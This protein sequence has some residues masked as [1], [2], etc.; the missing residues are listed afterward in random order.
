MHWTKE[1]DR[2]VEEKYYEIPV[3]ELMELLP[4][5]TQ[6][7]IELRAKRKLGLTKDKRTQRKY[8][9]NMNFFDEPNV[10]NSYW[11]GFIAADGCLT[12]KKHLVSFGIHWDDGY[13]LEQFIK[14]CEFEGKVVYTTTT[15]GWRKATLY[16]WGVAPW[17]E[18]LKKNYE[19]TPQKSLTLGPPNLVEE[20]HIKAYIRGYL[21]GDGHINDARVG[22]VG[23]EGTM[24][25]IKKQ[26]DILVPWHG[27]RGRSN[28]Y[29]GTGEKVYRYAV[30]GKRSRMLIKELL[31]V[32]TPYLERK[33]GKFIN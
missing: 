15:E 30:V 19:L 13:L 6:A 11:A 18:S 25:F 27:D 16:I 29:Q 9:I 33:W 12:K 28:V 26:V 14:D 10:L 1:E 2:L 8:N 5:R 22:F 21:D 4:G 24:E 32:E 23:S 3:K 17:F 20:E 31:K 7:A